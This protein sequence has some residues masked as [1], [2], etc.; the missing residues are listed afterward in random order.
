MKGTQLDDV[1]GK[2]PWLQKPLAKSLFCFCDAFLALPLARLRDGIPMTY[3]EFQLRCVVVAML[4]YLLRPLTTT[5]YLNLTV[6]FV[7]FE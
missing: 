7:V 2:R 4:I 1:L 5:L 6:S 3:I